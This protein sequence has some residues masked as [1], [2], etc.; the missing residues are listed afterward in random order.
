M[1]HPDIMKLFDC[2]EDEPDSNPVKRLHVK[3]DNNLSDDRQYIMLLI[4]SVQFLKDMVIGL[5]SVLLLLV[6]VILLLVRS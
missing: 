3:H 4:E 5:S 2:D 1:L 6:F